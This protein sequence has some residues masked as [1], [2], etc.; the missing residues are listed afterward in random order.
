MG[1]ENRRK[2]TR[3]EVSFQVELYTDKGNHLAAKVC[4]ISFGGA[5]LNYNIPRYGKLEVDSGCTCKLFVEGSEGAP[6]VV[7]ARVIHASGKGAGLEFIQTSPDDFDRFK[8][9]I[10]SQVD[11]PQALLDEL[12]RSASAHRASGSA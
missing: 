3:V 10:L 8:N 4:D 5:Y 1:E 2:H 6:I 12:N 7:E 9:Y 11:V